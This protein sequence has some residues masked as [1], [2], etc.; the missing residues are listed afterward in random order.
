MPRFPHWPQALQR[1]GPL[2]SSYMVIIDIQAVL[3]WTS[4]IHGF[5]PFHVHMLGYT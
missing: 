1:S 4:A 2:S 3:D 5:Y